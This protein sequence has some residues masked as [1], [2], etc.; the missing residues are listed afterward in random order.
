MCLHEKTNGTI[1]AVWQN[2]F[3]KGDTVKG[4]RADVTN[5]VKAE[6]QARGLVVISIRIEENTIYIECTN[7]TYK[8]RL[9][10]WM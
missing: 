8:E 9:D 2:W 4:Y 5:R 3:L 1:D 6:Y 10:D 7:K